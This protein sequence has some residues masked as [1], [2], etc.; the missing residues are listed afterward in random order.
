LRCVGLVNEAAYT[1]RSIIITFRFAV[2]VGIKYGTVDNPP[3]AC[4]Y[5]NS[6]TPVPAPSN[7]S[8][9]GPRTGTLSPPSI[10]A[11]VAPLSGQESSFDVS[12]DET[13]VLVYTSS[14]TKEI[15]L[16]VTGDFPAGYKLSDGNT[17]SS[18]SNTVTDYDM[19]YHIYIF[20]GS[21][22]RGAPNGH[23]SGPLTYGYDFYN[24][25]ATGIPVNY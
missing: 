16:G 4:V 8:I 5:T 2:D 10:N 9:E 22:T 19:H 21:I 24:S 1:Q 12:A 17:V 18:T 3:M 20:D 15:Q 7:F 25:T 14:G 6:S 11:N 13:R 23:L